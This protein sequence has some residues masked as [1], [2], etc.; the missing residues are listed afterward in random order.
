[1]NTI[2]FLSVDRMTVTH[3]GVTFSLN[4]LLKYLKPGEKLKVS[5]IG[6][7]IAKSYVL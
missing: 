5:T 3:I 1:M 7:I 4:H 2:Y 6:H